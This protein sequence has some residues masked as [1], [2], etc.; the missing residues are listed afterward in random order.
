M[1][2]VSPHTVVISS[3]SSSP[4][5]HGGCWGGPQMA[6]CCSCPAIQSLMPLVRVCR[7][8]HHSKEEC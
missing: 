5:L 6:V 2:A 7:L 3:S 8:C 1:G 4:F